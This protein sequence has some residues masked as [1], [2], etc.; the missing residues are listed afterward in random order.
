[1]NENELKKET[2]ET[3]KTIIKTTEKNMNSLNSQPIENKKFST[4]MYMGPSI[5]GVT[6]QNAV[7][8]N[9]IPEALEVFAN[10]NPAIKKFFVPLDRIHEVRQKL[11]DKSS[12][13]SMLY[14]DINKKIRVK[15]DNK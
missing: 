13:Y 2:L 7:Y 12:A 6:R 8:R 10:E 9:G 3:E 11:E 5:L 15:G 4:V 14:A 1:M